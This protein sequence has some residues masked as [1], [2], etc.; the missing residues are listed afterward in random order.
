MKCFYALLLLC[1][2]ISYEKINGIEYK[3]LYQSND[4]E[5]K[6]YYFYNP[7]QEAQIPSVEKFKLQGVEIYRDGVLIKDTFTNNNHL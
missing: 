5:L 2:L 6:I 4:N 7:E 3:V 1:L